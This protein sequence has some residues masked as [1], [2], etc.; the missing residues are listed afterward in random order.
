MV[1][2]A[3]IKASL[4]LNSVNVSM[5]C[6]MYIIL[7]IRKHAENCNESV[8]PFWLNTINSIALLEDIVDVST[9]I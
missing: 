3:E 2:Q 1:T 7:V 5:F 6:V 4:F 9:G 8:S